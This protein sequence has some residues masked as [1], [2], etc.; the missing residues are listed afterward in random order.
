MSLTK[1]FEEHN[2]KFSLKAD[3]SKISSIRA[4]GIAEYI[5][6]PSSKEQL[7]YAVRAAKAASYKYKI[8]GK[9]TNVFFSDNGFD[10][11]IISTS[12]MKNMSLEGN[13]F[14]A[15]AGIS[16]PFLIRSAAR[17]GFRIFPHLS[18]IPGSLGGAVRNNAGAY[19]KEMSDIFEWGEFYSAE[20]DSVLTLNG[21]E[22][23]FSYRNSRLTSTPLVLLSCKIRADE[24]CAADVL[25]EISYYSELRLQKQ[26]Q[27]PSLGSFFKRAGEYPASKL[28]DEC[29]LKGF[30]VGGASISAK[31]AGFIINN[32][33]ATARDI[34]ALADIARDA[35]FKKYGILLAREAE[36]IE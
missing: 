20:A 13:G 3:T 18:G 5:A 17:S 6:F 19:G 15:D 12:D 35:V 25:K 8:I 2:I 28:I 30:S 10:G 1:A 21:C 9:A 29:G 23:D 4:G 22:L 11:L 24:A 32:G 14:V 31:H 36:F 7:M 33:A 27:E 16:L 34:N 26:P